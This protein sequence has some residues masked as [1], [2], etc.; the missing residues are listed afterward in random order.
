MLFVVFVPETVLL[1]D[2]LSVE[3]FVVLLVPV[4]LSVKVPP[5]PLE[6]EPFVEFSVDVSAVPP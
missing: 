6:V 4:E 2:V 1:V 3:L 5:V